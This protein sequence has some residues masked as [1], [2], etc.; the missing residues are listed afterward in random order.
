MAS[1]FPIAATARWPRIPGL[2]ATLDSPTRLLG[3]W[4]LVWVLLLNLAF[5]PMWFVGGPSRAIPIGLLAAVVAY[6]VGLQV[7][8]GL[9]TRWV[10]APEQVREGP[11][12]RAQFGMF[13]GSALVGL[14]ITALTVAV[15]EALDGDPRVA[16][17]VAVGLSF[18]ATFALRRAIVFRPAA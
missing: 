2:G 11:A 6:C 8:W 14:A 17:L 7:H 12:R 4:L 3:N 18:T 13:V 1:A 15:G 10:F 5:M 9:A 16:K